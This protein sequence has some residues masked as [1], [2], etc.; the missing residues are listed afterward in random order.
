VSS[1]RLVAAQDWRLLWRN[2][3]GRI[4]VGLLM[5]LS[6]V[7][8]LTSI[9]HRDQG[10][11]LRTRFQA[12]A[13]SAFDGAPARHPHRMVHYGHFVFRPLPPLA[14]FD[15]GVD[16]YTGHALF[17]EGHRQN[18]ANFG[19]ARQSSLLI[20]F[21]QLTPAFV[22]QTLAPLLL[23]FVGFGCLARERERGTLRQLLAQGVPARTLLGGKLLALGGLAA[24]LLLPAVATLLWLMVTSAA[25]PAATALL[26]GGY[27]AYLAIWVLLITAASALALQARTALL[28]LIGIWGFTVILLPRLAPDVARAAIPLPARLENELSLARELTEI[29]DSHDPDDPYFAQFKEKVLREYGVKD[30]A[31]LPVNYRGLLAIEGERL[32]SELFDKYMAR[33]FAIQHRQ[34]RLSDLFAL[35]SPTIA[36]R[37]LSLAASGMDLEGHRRFLAQAEAYRFDIV[38]RLNRLQAEALTW[39]DDGN[40][41][42]DVEAANRVR[43]DPQHWRDVPDFLY[44]ATPVRENLR[45]ALPGA[46]LLLAWLLFMGGLARF[47]LQRMGRMA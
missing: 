9:A 47:V 46:G 39:S 40:R 16:A 21:G 34:N 27:A 8:A 2:T 22:L 24:L 3:V 14:A 23:V 6:A 17:L 28:A 41:Y 37:R 12:D 29:G 33:D 4:A 42:K 31:D 10:D 13:D 30:V 35:A 45:A 38:Q 25:P 5:L 36:V 32:T 7:A 26:I 1:L 11:A 19:D 43:I 20:R 44:E 15:P 18:S